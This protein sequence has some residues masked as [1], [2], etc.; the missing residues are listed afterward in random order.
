V[1]RLGWILVL[2]GVGVALAIL[3]GVLATRN[4]QTK[5]EAASSL[6]SSLNTL[7]ESV[8]ALTNINPSSATSSDVQ[9]DLAAVESNWAQVQSDFNAVQNAPSGPLE[10]AWSSFTSAIKDIPNASS[11][12]DAVNSVSSA[13]QQLVSAAQSTAS[14]I[15]CSNGGA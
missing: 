2:V 3:I 13:A 12:S 14:S 15:D 11:V 9:S 8:K 6:C 4:E 5:T 1:S 7:Q 10:D